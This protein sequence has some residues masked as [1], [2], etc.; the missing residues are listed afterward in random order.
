[1]KSLILHLSKFLFIECNNMQTNRL[2]IAEFFKQQTKLRYVDIHSHWLQQKIQWKFIHMN[3]IFIKW[4]I[5]NDF[6]KA[7][8]FANFETFVKMI[9]FE[10]K[11]SLFFNI[12]WKNIFKYAFVEKNK[13]KYFETFEFEFAKHWN[14]KKQICSWFMNFKKL[15]ISYL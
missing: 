1:M 15:V 7:F 2:L 4:M 13:I 9:G 3:W 11:I 14:V 5:V 8:T 12:Q 10:N 6:I